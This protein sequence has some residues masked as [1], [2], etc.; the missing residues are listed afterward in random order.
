MTGLKSAGNEFTLDLW[1]ELLIKEWN[2]KRTHDKKIY[3]ARGISWTLLRK[4]KTK[5]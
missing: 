4:M 3:I 2:R 5:H 1:Y